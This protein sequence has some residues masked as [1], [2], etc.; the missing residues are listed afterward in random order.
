MCVKD[1]HEILLTDCINIIHAAIRLCLEIKSFRKAI[2]VGHRDNESV[3]Q[4]QK[5]NLIENKLI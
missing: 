4:I 3:G 1:D 5:H 2:S